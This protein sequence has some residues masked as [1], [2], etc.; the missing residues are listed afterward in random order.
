[1]L[2]RLRLWRNDNDSMFLPVFDALHIL[3]PVE[4]YAAATLSLAKRIAKH[5]D[6]LCVCV[7]VMHENINDR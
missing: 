7:R 3:L 2:R 5:R 6:G 1:M 4:W